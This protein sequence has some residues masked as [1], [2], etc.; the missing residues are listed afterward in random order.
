MCTLAYAPRIG[1]PRSRELLRQ[2]IH[3]VLAIARWGGYRELVLGAWGCGAFE[4]VVFA[5]TD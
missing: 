4:T 3:R 2:R 1:Q 5:V